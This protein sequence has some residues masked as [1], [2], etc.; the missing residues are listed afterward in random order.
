MGGRVV[1]IHLAE[2]RAQWRVVAVNTAVNV[3][4]PYRRGT[5]WVTVTFLKGNSPCCQIKWPGIGCHITHLLWRLETRQKR[6]QLYRCSNEVL[7]ITS[8]NSFSLR[9]YGPFTA[10]LQE[11]VA[12]PEK[13]SRSKNRTAICRGV[14]TLQ[15]LR[16]K[17]RP[18]KLKLRTL[19][20]TYKTTGDTECLR[21]RHW[22]EYLHVREAVTGGCRKLHAETGFMIRSLHT[23]LILLEWLN[24]GDGDRRHM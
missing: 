1:R 23:G 21:R 7:L 16:P 4:Y 8:S 2:D 11:C 12:L 17:T 22:W 5:D 9:V 3:W 14:S 10:E 19:S 13:I 24:Q 15:S 18:Q 20:K 6:D